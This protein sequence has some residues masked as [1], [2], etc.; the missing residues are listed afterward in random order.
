MKKTSLLLAISA[1][2]Y[3]TYALAEDQLYA[4]MPTA[5]VEKI[6]DEMDIS[7][8]PTGG[9]SENTP[10]PGLASFMGLDPA[11]RL[12]NNI[13]VDS[14]NA[15][16]LPQ[17]CPESFAVNGY[18]MA[19]FPVTVTFGDGNQETQWWTAGTGTKGFVAGTGWLLAQKDDTWNHRWTLFTNTGV[20]IKQ[21]VL[22]PLE[23]KASGD[24]PGEKRVY[25]FDIGGKMPGAPAPATPEHT[26][27]SARGQFVKQTLPTAPSPIFTATYTDP[28]YTVTH[29]TDP[30][31]NNAPLDG[32]TIP[33]NEAPKLSNNYRKPTHDL[34]G[35]LTIDFP[36]PVGGTTPIEAIDFAYIADTDCVL[37]V[38]EGEILSY[39][40]QTSTLVMKILAEN[41]GLAAIMQRC[42][43]NVSTIAGPFD[44][45]G[46]D[47]ITASLQLQS[48]CCYSL[49][50]VDTLETVKLLKVNT[51]ADNE[52]CVPNNLKK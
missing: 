13:A 28:V 52:Y 31:T 46:D 32:N 18:E 35:T 5:A 22:K 23:R 15:I 49:M 36:T 4:G 19:K 48:D 14:S 44:L 42:G 20:S 43:A 51:N 8:E 47:T 34:Y 7:E 50:N 38:R 37:P 25:T 45:T 41:G 30:Q 3:G 10:D 17:M 26:P 39:D 9:M 24:N 29:D 11:Q 27:G 21:I 40:P 2:L 16:Y 6:L 33:L 12:P 1:L